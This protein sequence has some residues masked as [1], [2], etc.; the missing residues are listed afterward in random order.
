MDQ[1][2]N[3]LLEL[4]RDRS[5]ERL[6]GRLNPVNIFELAG[7]TNQEIRH[8]HFLAEVLNPSSRLGIGPDVL[9]ALVR[10]CLPNIEDRI[11]DFDAFDI[12][13]GSAS[14]VNVYREMANIDLLIVDDE[15]EFV[16]A[17]ENKVDAAESDGQLEKYRRYICSHNDYGTYKKLFVYLT[18]E[19]RPPD[20]D[21][22]WVPVSY[23]TIRNGIRARLEK[24]N[25]SQ[26]TQLILS[27]YCD[28]LEQRVM[29]KQELEEIANK[30]YQEHREALDFI[31][32]TKRDNIGIISIELKK[33]IMG[34]VDFDFYSLSE[35]RSSKSSLRY[36]TASMRR[37]SE[38]LP[39]VIGWNDG[40][41]IC[42]EISIRKNNISCKIVL[43]PT[44]DE[45]TRTFVRERLT[46]KYKRQSAS[47]TWTTIKSWALYSPKNGD[48]LDSCD[49]EDVVMH[50]SE[51]F[52]RVFT[53]N[54]R[55]LDEEIAAII[56]GLASSSSS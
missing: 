38:V 18:P 15:A 30:I 47:P 17:I 36:T 27:H 20:G 45:Y 41:A 50:C 39:A 9:R 6:T 3:A 16:I 25:I 33:K 24:G 11:N 19:G 2:K 31:F 1:M 4:L 29:K 53:E 12:E 55:S 13:L 32:E 46:R 22:S 23:Q 43:G 44:G 26:S 7:L 56:T 21:R 10:E 48:D 14:S 51:K 54:A 52:V 35:A 34:A 28:L 49:A 42:W 5:L 40:I 8:S 37:L